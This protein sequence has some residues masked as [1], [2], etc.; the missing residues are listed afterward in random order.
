MPSQKFRAGVVIAIRRENG[1]LMCF[2]RSDV[3]DSW[4][5]PQGGIDVGELPVDAAWRELTEE[6]GLTQ[7]DVH[8]VSELP[9]W[10]TYE[11][12]TAVREAMP[13]GGKRIGQTQKWFLFGLLD[14]P[15]IEPKPDGVEFVGWPQWLLIDAR[16][17]ALGE[18]E[19]R[20]RIKLVE[21]ED[22]LRVAKG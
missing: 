8:L 9:E 16:E 10:I 12:P 1:D 6:T 21:R 2:Q 13:D 20:E 3:H 18:A 5:L 14:E 4:Q 22:F 11:Y 15:N 19:G 17:K 7:G